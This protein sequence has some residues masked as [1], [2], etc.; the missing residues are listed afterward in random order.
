MLLQKNKNLFEKVSNVMINGMKKK[1]EI[2]LFALIRM[3]VTWLVKKT[4]ANWLI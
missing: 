1:I 4:H 2:C 3:Q